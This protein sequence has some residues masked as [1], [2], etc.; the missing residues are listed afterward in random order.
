[1]EK[2][3]RREHEFRYTRENH[4]DKR[5]KWSSS[6]RR[7]GPTANEVGGSQQEPPRPMTRVGSVGEWAFVN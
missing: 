1:M 7:L 4:E 2:E 6:S 3:G 5:A